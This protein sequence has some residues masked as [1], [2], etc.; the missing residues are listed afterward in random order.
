MEK[1]KCHA[2][3]TVCPN[4]KCVPQMDAI[5]QDPDIGMRIKE[6]SLVQEDVKKGQPWQKKLQEAPQKKN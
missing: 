1:N 2:L 4:G 5:M 6:G 3:S